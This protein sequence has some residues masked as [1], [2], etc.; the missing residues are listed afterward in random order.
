MSNVQGK[1]PLQLIRYSEGRFEVP[2]ETAE[3]L[4]GFTRPLAL[5]TIV[6]KYRTGKSLLLNKVLLKQPSF[7]VSPTIHSCTKGLWLSKQ[8][9]RN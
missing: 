4:R 8:T 2:F 9:L 5:V 7:S 3:F 6:G 1:A